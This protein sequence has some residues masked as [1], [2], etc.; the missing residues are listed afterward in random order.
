MTSGEL[1]TGDLKILAEH[2]HVVKASVAE[3]RALFDQVEDEE[4]GTALDKAQ[5]AVHSDSAG[6]AYVVIVI[7]P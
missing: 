5:G 4:L 6:R 2:A 7:D 3:A 1:S